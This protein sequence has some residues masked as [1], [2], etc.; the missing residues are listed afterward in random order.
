[1]NSDSQPDEPEAASL[2]GRS[3][4][5]VRPIVVA[6]LALML[7]ALAAA[8][9]KSYRDLD[10]AWDRESELDREIVSA[11]TRLEDLEAGL[12][13][14]RHDP[15]TLERL[16]REELGFVAPG[17]VVIVLPEAVEDQ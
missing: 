17:E 14:L 3:G 16:A 10:R 4:R 9:A 8:A 12:D 11:Q 13:R 7:L 6:A 1:M 2:R 5:S 15:M